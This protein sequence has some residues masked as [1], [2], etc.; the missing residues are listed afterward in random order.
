M[1]DLAAQRLGILVVR[2]DVH[3]AVRA[4]V[5]QGHGGPDRRVL[6]ERQLVR[7]GEFLS[8]CRQRGRNVALGS[9]RSS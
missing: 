5:G 8:R 3:R 4:S 7:G 2:V 1:R 9:Y 6:H